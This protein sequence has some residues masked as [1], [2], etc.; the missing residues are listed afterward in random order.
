MYQRTVT[1]EGLGQVS[2]RSASNTSPQEA[3]WRQRLEAEER[4]KLV[5]HADV[6]SET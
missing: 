6:I 5:A 1:G 3:A 2:C 4:V